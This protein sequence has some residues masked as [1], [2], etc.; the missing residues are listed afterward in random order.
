[1]DA[2]EQIERLEQHFGR[3]LDQHERLVTRLGEISVAVLG[4]IRENGSPEYLLVSFEDGGLE[5]MSEGGFLK[6]RLNNYGFVGIFAYANGYAD[7]SVEPGQD[8]VARL[9]RRYSFIL[10]SPSREARATSALG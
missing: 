8:A 1:M 6:A 2:H 7:A 3:S 10:S 9:V 5:S 4:T